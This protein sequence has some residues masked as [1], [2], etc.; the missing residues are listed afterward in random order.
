MQNNHCTHI[1]Y[2]WGQTMVYKLLILGNGFDLHAGLK[3]SF[4]D[5]FEKEEKPIID[6]WIKG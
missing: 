1:I 2:N 5:F 6:T 4:T 3:S